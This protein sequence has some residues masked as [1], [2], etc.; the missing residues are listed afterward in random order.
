MRVRWVLQGRVEREL[1]V[2]L[3]H[4]LLRRARV[5]LVAH[6]LLWRAPLVRHEA[7]HAGLVLSR[8]AR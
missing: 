3:H 8:H 1:T 6:V 4:E 7:A 5:A 2:R